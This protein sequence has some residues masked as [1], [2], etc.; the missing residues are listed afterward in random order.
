MSYKLNY[1]KFLSLVYIVSICFSNKTLGNNIDC[2]S[3]FY[4]RIEAGG[5]FSKCASICA[6]PRAWDPAREGYDADLNNAPFASISM[7]YNINSY[8]SIGASFTYRGPFKYCKRQTPLETSGTPAF[9]GEKTRFFD[10]ENNSFMLDFYLNRSGIN[11]YYNYDVYCGNISPYLGV[12]IGW[13]KNAVYNFHSQLSETIQVNNF[14][15]NRVASIMTYKVDNEFAWQI[16]LGVDYNI[17]SCINIGLGYR[18]F[19]GGCF[20]TNNY[21]VDN[22]P[23]YIREVNLPAWTGKLKTN[24]IVASFTLE[25]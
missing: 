24:E 19:D 6:D 12:G 15:T 1:K 25:F 20:K 5:S 10:L 7:G 21:V 16:S 3:P 13:S 11:S 18:Y 17:N 23:D 8:M 4:S 14:T 2:I 9:L 22:L